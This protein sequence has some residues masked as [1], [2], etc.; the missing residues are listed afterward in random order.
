ME[1]IRTIIRWFKAL[2]IQFKL[3]VFVVVLLAISGILRLITPEVT[4]ES[5]LL[6]ITSGVVGPKSLESVTIS[7]DLPQLSEEVPLY[8]GANATVSPVEFATFLASQFGLP[9]S[10]ELPNRWVDSESGISIDYRD[11]SKQILYLQYFEETDEN[12]TPNREQAIS[13]AETFIK[14][15]L[16]IENVSP[17]I[18]NV[19]FHGEESVVTQA[20]ATHVVVPFVFAI[21]GIQTYYEGARDTYALVYIDA[22][23]RVVKA[24]FFTPPPNPTQY[25]VADPLNKNTLERSIKSGNGEIIGSTSV[26]RFTIT[27]LQ[28]LDI[29][30]IE[31]EY[32][33]SVRDNRFYPYFRMI[34]D[35]ETADGTIARVTLIHPAVELQ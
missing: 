30:L 9:K 17:Q 8:Q 34:G 32:R 28:N 13:V 2:P 35:G 16:G 23:S 27:D 6:P 12:A 25:A 29:Q 14:D 20:N 18:A 5:I 26:Q 31:L 19:Q 33:Y 4:P 15:T 21:D 24:E 10:R 7:G 11:Y 3:F 22:E 1:K